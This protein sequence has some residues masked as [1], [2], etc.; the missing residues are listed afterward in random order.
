MMNS[1]Y[2][3]SFANLYIFVYLRSI[4]VIS[5]CFN[6][7]NIACLRRDFMEIGEVIEPEENYNVPGNGIEDGNA[8]R[9]H[10]TNTYFV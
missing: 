7:H 5:S 10:I 8:M 4:P 6:L 1:F 2:V 9:T 3:K